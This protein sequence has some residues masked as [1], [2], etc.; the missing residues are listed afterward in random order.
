MPTVETIRA[1]LLSRRRQL[2][3]AVAR[4]EEDLHWLGTDARPE[5]V[6][7]GQEENLVRLLDRMDARMKAEIEA[8]DRALVKLETGRYGHCEFCGNEIGRAPGG[9]TLGGPLRLVR[10]DRGDKPAGGM[11]LR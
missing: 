8:I 6:E 2:F 5:L 4:T 11:M 9:A 3:V 7:K 10:P 1:D